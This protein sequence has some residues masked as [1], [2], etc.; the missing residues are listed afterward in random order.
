MLTAWRGLLNAQREVLGPHKISHA[1]KWQ[2][3]S[4]P[5]NS[6]VVEARW[7]YRDSMEVIARAQGSLF[8]AYSLLTVPSP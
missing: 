4:A 3:S 6:E 8:A 7:V 1:I 5:L 2:G